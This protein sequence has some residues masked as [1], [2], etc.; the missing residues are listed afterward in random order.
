MWNL[1]LDNQIIIRIYFLTRLTSS[2]NLKLLR[3]NEAAL[4][5]I[6]YDDKVDG[7]SCTCIFFSIGK[8]MALHNVFKVKF[9]L[10]IK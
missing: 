7:V 8:K 6:H 9:E 10:I 1:F 3:S 5:F 4:I 2:R